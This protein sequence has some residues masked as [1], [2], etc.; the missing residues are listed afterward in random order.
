[1]KFWYRSLV[2]DPCRYKRPVHLYMIFA[3]IC[4]IASF[5]GTYPI[6]LIG[7]ISEKFYGILQFV[8][9]SFIG[10]PFV[11]W[12][13]VGVVLIYPIVLLAI[14][15]IA[16][17]CKNYLPL[18]IVAI[19]GV[20]Y[21]ISVLIAMICTGGFTLEAFLMTIS[22]LVNMWFSVYFVSVWKYLKPERKLQENP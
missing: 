4:Y 10:I 19:L 3:V 13:M 7:R 22:I 15:L 1:M 14:Y 16:I 9:Y 8:V 5:L 2:E 21:S 18:M 6:I 11:H 17:F 12:F 20:V